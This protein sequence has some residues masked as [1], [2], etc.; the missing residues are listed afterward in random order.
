MPFPKTEYAAAWAGAALG[1]TAVVV[2]VLLAKRIR[3]RYGVRL[4][5]TKPGLVACIGVWLNVL[6]IPMELITLYATYSSAASRV[7]L[8]DCG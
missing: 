8:G 2:Y 5:E 7:V 6:T 3:R 4:R 1:V